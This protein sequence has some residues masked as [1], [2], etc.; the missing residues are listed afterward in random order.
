MRN[1]SILEEKTGGVP[2]KK[3]AT[4]SQGFFNATKIAA[5]PILP[6]G[7]AVLRIAVKRL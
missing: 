6:V 1:G 5:E 7:Q 4:Q 2:N 3:T